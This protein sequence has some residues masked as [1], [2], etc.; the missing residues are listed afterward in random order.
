MIKTNSANVSRLEV[1]A[2]LNALPQVELSVVAGVP[3]PELGELV[4]AAVVRA[5]GSD[6]GEAELQAALRETLSGYKVPVASSSSP[7]MTSRGRPPGRCGS[8]T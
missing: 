8:P 5:E 6:A 3:D 1:E 7:T 4:V 2:A